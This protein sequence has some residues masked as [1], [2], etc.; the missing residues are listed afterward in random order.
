MINYLIE[1]ILYIVKGIA[2][3][4]ASSLSSMDFMNSKNLN[5]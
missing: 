2:Y 4:N 1:K 3:G 5:N